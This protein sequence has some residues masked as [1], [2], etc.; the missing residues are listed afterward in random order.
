MI[1]KYTYMVWASSLS[2]LSNKY[3]GKIK[4]EN[5]ALTRIH[6]YMGKIDLGAQMLVN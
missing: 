6:N 1:T 4:L 5:T 3:A 2:K